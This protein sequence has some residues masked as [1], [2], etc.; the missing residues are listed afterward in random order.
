MTRIYWP[1]P[2]GDVWGGYYGGAKI[3]SGA[4]LAVTADGKRHPLGE[5]RYCGN[6]FDEC[7][8]PEGFNE[9]G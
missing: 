5:C 6:V 7:Y 8:C 2:V 4:P 1:E 3:V 9:P